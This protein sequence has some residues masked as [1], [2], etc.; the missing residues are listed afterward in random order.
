MSNFYNTGE[1]VVLVHANPNRTLLLIGNLSD[2]TLYVSPDGEVQN[3]NE[4]AW[5]VKIDGNVEITGPGCYKGD[6]YASVS[7]TSDIRV[8]EV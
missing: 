7:A 8:F 4:R 2:T 6:I 3:F 5:P 1:P